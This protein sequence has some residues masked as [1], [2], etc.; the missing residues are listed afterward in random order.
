VIAL[1]L[2]AVTGL[3]AEPPG[4]YLRDSSGKVTR[5]GYEECWHDRN[6]NT[7]QDPAP[8]CGD[9]VPV[10]AADSDGDGVTDDRDRCPDTP[11]GAR[12]DADGCPLDADGD[13]VYDGLDR[14]PDTP[15][16]ARVDAQGC[17]L[18][19]DRDGVYDG[20][21]QCP[22]TVP[23]AKVDDRGCEIPAVITLQ[24]VT[25]EVNTADLR[26]E[27]RGVLD[28][29]A[30]RLKANPTVKVEVAGHTDNTGEAAYNL[31]LSQRRAEAVR[32]YLVGRGV[33]AGQLS[34]RG[35]GETS[36]VANNSTRAGRERN[37]RVE[38]I[39]Q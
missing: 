16:G 25:F 22:D 34:A 28:D 3:A 29:M 21:D 9:V 20:L 19:G 36:P 38:L 33:P 30:E 15:E 7:P 26:P 32:D 6:V 27:S 35:Y 10:A 12:V 2:F 17:P 23:G 18:D 8:E 31:D 5:S 11:S 14:C 39:V 4:D 1:G 37:R 24:G 13:G